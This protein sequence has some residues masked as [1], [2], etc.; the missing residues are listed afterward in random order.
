[1]ALGETGFNMWYAQMLSGDADLY[2]VLI[3]H[4]NEYID[5]AIYEGAVTE[6]RGGGRYRIGLVT[7]NSTHAFYS[8]FSHLYM[9]YCMTGQEHY[10]RAM[11]EMADY[12]YR[13]AM[14]TN[15]M[16]FHMVTTGAWTNGYFSMRNM[17]EIRYAFMIRAMYY[18]Y[19]IFGDEKYLYIGDEVAKWVEATQ[20]ENGSWSQAYNEDGSN[21]YNTILK[22]VLFKNYIMLYALRGPAE[23]YRQTGCERLREPMIKF[24]DYLLSE[25][26]ND[27]WMWDPVAD[28]SITETNEDMQR[29]NAPMQEIMAT[30][31]LEL[32][33]DMTGE[34]KYFDGMCKFLRYYLGSM[35]NYGTAPQRY[36]YKDYAGGKVRMPMLGMTSTLS[37]I[38]NK[39]IAAF[40]KNRALAE[41]LGFKD[42]VDIF[43]DG[44]IHSPEK[45]SGDYNY[46]DVTAH[47]FE[48]EQDKWLYVVNHSGYNSEQ[49]W[50]KTIDVKTRCDGYIWSDCEN[51][52]DN[53]YETKASRYYEIFEMATMKLLPIRVSEFTDTV[54]ITA[55]TYDENSIELKVTGSSGTAGLEIHDGDFNIT[56]GNKYYVSIVQNGNEKSIA[57]KADNNGNYTA[58]D[59]KLTINLSFADNQ[60]S[61]EDIQNHWAKSDIEAISAMGLLRGVGGNLFAPEGTV[62]KREFILMAMR[63]MGYQN[64]EEAT[65]KAVELGIVDAK[66]NL[67]E[68]VKRDE[69]T[70][71]CVKVLEQCR[72]MSDM[73]IETESHKI[74]GEIADD[75]EAVKADAESITL[76]DFEPTKNNLSLPYEGMYGSYITWES[77]DED[78]ISKEGIITKPPVGQEKTVTMTATI[79]RNNAE[80]K[81]IFELEVPDQ[82]KLSYA[83]NHPI[84]NS[85]IRVNSAGAVFDFS[86]DAI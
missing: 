10:K 25:M 45:V 6:G 56:D 9:S 59:G 5:D 16:G 33:Y 50:E 57:V 7:K 60:N 81:K 64:D 19:E 47:I 20:E 55:K 35:Q 49:I 69:M 12:V 27:Q 30:E 67:D 40:E 38:D 79:K 51:I 58:S 48:T 84:A 22:Q 53:I 28:K 77:S 80:E 86:F 43:A 11:A 34:E 21:Y 18:S 78:I 26:Q 23:Y 62:T 8:E 29:G 71:I 65:G 72:D 3:E 63:V 70:N 83:A 61:Y 73:R 32:V 31:I 74:R 17:A 36:C 66:E 37:R 44:A 76:S 13:N 4:E 2:D 15:L 85:L 46:I 14:A 75:Q 24:A 41:K 54:K 42:L 52:I 39:L 82:S 1:M 68:P